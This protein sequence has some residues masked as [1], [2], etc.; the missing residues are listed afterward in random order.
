MRKNMDWAPGPGVRIVGVARDGDCWVISAAGPEVGFCP[1]CQEPSTR[2]H[3][4]Y[5]RHLQDLPV[6]GAAV[7]VKMQVSRWRCLNRECER[8]TFTDQLPEIVCPHARRTQRIDELVH[9]FGHG[10]G[11][12][13]GGLWCKRWRSSQLG[14]WK[15]PW[16]TQRAPHSKSRERFC[17]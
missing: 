16:I 11:G 5:F 1:G 17:I 13:S 7:V 10:T 6:Q 4:R 12:R 3:S 14:A 9:L 15:S 2:R 8:E